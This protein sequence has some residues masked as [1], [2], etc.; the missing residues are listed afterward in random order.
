MSSVPHHSIAI[1][2][3]GFA[4]I[5]AAIRLLQEG[6]TDLVLFE[7]AE[8]VGGVWQANTYPGAACDVQS[9]LYAFSFA[10]NPDWSRKYSRQAEI[11]T[12]LE[13]VAER[14]G[15]L[16]HVRFGHTVGDCVWD[17]AAALWHIE[18]DQGEHTADV[19]I[20]A[21]GALE[22]PRLPDIPGLGE[23]TG[24]VMHTARWD[25]SVD[26]NGAR[27]AVVGTGASAIQVIPAIQPLV[28]ELT[29]FQRTP[30]WVIARGDGAFDETTR[31]RFRQRPVVQRALRRALFAYHETLGLAFRHT[32]ANRI[33]E[34]V[35]ARLH[36]RRQV[37]DP[38]LRAR[39]T[40]DYRIGCK[41]ILLSDDYYPALQQPNVNLVDGALAEVRG[42]TLIGADGSEHEADVIVLATGFY[43]TDLPF[44]EQVVGREGRR[45]SEIWGESPLAHLG[46]TVH[47]VPNF[48]LLMGPNTGL[49]HSSV[50]LMAEAQIEHTVGALRAMR[51]R[52]L[53]AIEPNAE[54][55]QAWKDEV[56]AMSERTVWQTGCASWYLDATGRN[57]ALWP[58]SVPAFRKR[59]E[60]FRPA[61][62]HL[63]RQPAEADHVVA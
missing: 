31:R 45:L 3:T 4:G 29:V 15:V 37:T 5:G 48:F 53:A 6:E 21:P 20:A 46:T 36:L 49:G 22:E 10:P 60:P 61:D 7:K 8:T 25:H 54:A 12:Y 41:R 34:S 40:P 38:D 56:D 39:L 18:T 32:W 55:Q 27:V 1:V 19:L 59:V 2:G 58:G 28:G 43:V 30:P 16:P 33:A 14:F 63:A 47:G 44:A 50:I 13:D 51:E 24:T 9:H 26:L 62:Y 52:H 57:A 35:K 17:E 23:F 42:S 11:R